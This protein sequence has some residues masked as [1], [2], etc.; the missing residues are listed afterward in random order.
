VL[1]DL[2]QM[3]GSV[4]TTSVLGRRSLG[5]RA[6]RIPDCHHQRHAGSGRGAAT[7]VRHRLALVTVVVRL[8]KNLNVI[9]II[10]EVFLYSSIKDPNLS[11]KNTKPGL[12]FFF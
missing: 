5:A 1:Q 3:K 4:A 6:R 7:L 8:S 2:D 11:R 9:F 10:F 12:V